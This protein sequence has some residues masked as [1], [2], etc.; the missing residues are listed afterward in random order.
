MQLKNN[1]ERAKWILSIFYLMLAFS[2][3]VIVSDIMEYN[4]LLGEF[5]TE[6]GDSNDLRQTIVGLLD[7]IIYIAAIVFFIMWFRRAYNNLQAAGVRILHA[8]GWA[9]G[10]WFVPILNLFRPYQIMEEIW[11]Q[12]QNLIGNSPL[13]SKSIIGFW[14]GMMVLNGIVD[15]ISSRM[16]LSANTLEDYQSSAFW[17]MLLDT[18]TVIPLLLIIMIIRTVSAWEDQLFNQS[19]EMPIEDHLI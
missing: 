13:A 10:C 16:M 19:F 4:L 5:S 7:L 2:P 17:T 18:S 3:I 9:A 1:K 8:E 6:E 14:W 11:E 15:R 12:T